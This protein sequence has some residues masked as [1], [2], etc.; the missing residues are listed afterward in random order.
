MNV[1]S[2][3]LGFRSGES[4]L[5]DEVAEAR[6]LRLVRE[7]RK[8]RVRLREASGEIGTKTPPLR[9]RRQLVVVVAA[10][11]GLFWSPIEKPES[12][13]AWSLELLAQSTVRLVQD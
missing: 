5:S 9:P 1:N 2:L 6:A 7:R 13:A 4:S 11:A 8:V 3:G 12:E 10:E